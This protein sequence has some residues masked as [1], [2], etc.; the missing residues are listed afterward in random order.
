[1]VHRSEEKPSAN[2][3]AIIAAEL[4]YHYNYL[5]ALLSEVEGITIEK[6]FI[7]K[8]QNG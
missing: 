8:K 5:S 3:S 2:L 6:Y 1:M 7:G 4:H